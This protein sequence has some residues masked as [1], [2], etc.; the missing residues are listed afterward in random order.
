MQRDDLGVR[1][2]VLR[3]VAAAEVNPFDHV[4][5][6]RACWHVDHQI[7]EG[8]V[9][10]AK[11]LPR[12]HG[13]RGVWPEER[14][15]LDAFRQPAERLRDKLELIRTGFADADEK[16]SSVDGETGE[17][18]RHLLFCPRRRAHFALQLEMVRL[19][20]V[21]TLGCRPKLSLGGDRK[22]RLLGA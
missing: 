7:T 21:S 13:K 18:P 11:D 8:G 5:H 22:V 9:R 3:S 17:V 14:N 12:N 2:D 4:G 10:L 6:R 16:R 15:L 1:Q 19:T 20:K